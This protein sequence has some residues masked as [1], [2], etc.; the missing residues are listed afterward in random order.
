VGVIGTGVQPSGI[1]ILFKTRRRWAER[2]MT[3]GSRPR[4]GCQAL[5]WRL[6]RGR[7]VPCEHIFPQFHVDFAHLW[8]VAPYEERRPRCSKLHMNRISLPNVCAALEAAP[9]DRLFTT[10]GRVLEVHRLRGSCYFTLAPSEVVG[11]TDSDARLPCALLR[12]NA[13]RTDFWVMA[14]Q[15]IEVTGYAEQF[16]GQWQLY[17]VQARR[18]NRVSLAS[19]CA[20]LETALPDR[21]FT[22]QGWVADVHR[23]RSSCYFTLADSDTRLP[24]ALLRHN[25]VHTDFWVTVGQEI[26]AT[27][28]AERFR[29]QW[30]LYVLEA[31][32]VHGDPGWPHRYY[33]Y[34]SARR[35]V[36]AFDTLM[37]AL[38]GPPKE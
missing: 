35:V 5:S 4:L 37:E 31:R 20:A 3:I 12:A 29:G 24:C 9:P 25:V 1:H 13:A 11:L 15:E 26:E 34:R 7:Y 38:F 16:R 10:R 21:L 36:V 19:V 2:S 32:L 18:V 17:V 22:T 23:V 6:R 8:A 30:Q 33:R 14:G 27:G 28:H